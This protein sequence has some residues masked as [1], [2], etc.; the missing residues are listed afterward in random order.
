M[1]LGTSY[2][3]LQIY[4]IENFLAFRDSPIKALAF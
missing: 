4:I 1:E 3:T 2:P